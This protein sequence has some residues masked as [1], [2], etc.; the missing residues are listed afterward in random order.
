MF[1][2][3]LLRVYLGAGVLGYGFA[4]PNNPI[5]LTSSL[6]SLFT[7]KS[8][9]SQKLLLTIL[10]SLLPPSLFI[11]VTRGKLCDMTSITQIKNF[12][13]VLSPPWGNLTHFNN[14]H[15][16]LFN[17]TDFPMLGNVIF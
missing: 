4:F 5:V 2:A 7:L 1:L 17:F 16:V 15:R 12:S 6:V 9:L 13:V 3:N 8:N 10:D 11:Y 14:I